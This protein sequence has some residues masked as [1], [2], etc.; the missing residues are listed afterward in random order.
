MTQRSP[1][2][3]SSPVIGLQ[4]YSVKDELDKDLPGTLRA[5]AAMGCRTVEAANF[6]T[7]LD[8]VQLRTAL[9]A[10]GMDCLSA[11]VPLPFL[12]GDLEPLIAEMKALGVRYVVCTAPWVEDNARYMQAA[13]QGSME[14]AFGDLM[15]TLTLDDWRW[16]A[17]QLNRIGSELHAAGLQLA[18]HNHGFEFKTFEGKTAYEHLLALTYPEHVA[19]ELDCGWIANAGFD[20]V[21]YLNRHGNRIALLHLKDLTRA[22]PG[23]TGLQLAG[24][25]LGGGIVD[26]PAV[27][28]AAARAGVAAC[29]I[30]QEAPFPAPVLEELEASF[31][32]LASLTVRS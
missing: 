12:L 6:A 15:H 2:A 4:L 24:I 9:D 18:Y 19:F 28:A 10:V 25:H 11:H 7:N 23:G 21:D 17:A 31:A 22:E 13:E 26:W 16:N 1:E 5:L 27:L 29:F 20:P 30:E 3:P 8:P 14:S 32:Y